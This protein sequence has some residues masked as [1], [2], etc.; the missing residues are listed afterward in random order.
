[1]KNLKRLFGKIKKWWKEDFSM[2]ELGKAAAQ[3]IHR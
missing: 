3:A 2:A 1:M